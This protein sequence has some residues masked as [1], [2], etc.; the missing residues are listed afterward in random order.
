MN[1]AQEVNECEEPFCL[2]ML[3]SELWASSRSPRPDEFLRSPRRLACEGGS[4]SGIIPTFFVF[5][6]E[7]LDSL[8]QEEENHERRRFAKD[9]GLDAPGKKHLERDYF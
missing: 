9:C 1:A 6:A 5:V 8:L 4:T 2:L 7:N 3:E